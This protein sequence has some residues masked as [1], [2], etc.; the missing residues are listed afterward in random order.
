M[1]THV[2]IM[3]GA[4]DLLFQGTRQELSARAPQK[5]HHSGRPPRGGAARAGVE[6]PHSGREAGAFVIRGATNE[7]AREV[8]RLL[9]EN[10][11]RRASPGGGAGDAG[12]AVRQDHRWS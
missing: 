1:A 9:V 5:L 4:G 3:S 11:D 12:G 2:G 6:R 8:N 7:M 10:G